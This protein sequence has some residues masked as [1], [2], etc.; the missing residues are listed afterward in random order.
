MVR[1][2]NTRNSTH[3]TMHEENTSW[4]TLLHCSKNKLWRRICAD[5]FQVLLPF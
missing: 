2:E 3:D 4:L 1:A 5:T